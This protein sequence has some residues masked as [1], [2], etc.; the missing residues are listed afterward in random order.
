[1]VLPNNQFEAG[2]FFFFFQANLFTCGEILFI[3]GHNEPFQYD[4]AYHREKLMLN[5]KK[6]KNNRNKTK[7]R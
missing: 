6:Q 2:C 4:Q 7:L 3:K 1:M 5:K